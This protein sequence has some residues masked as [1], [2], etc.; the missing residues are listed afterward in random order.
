MRPG[1]FIDSRVAVDDVLHMTLRPSSSCCQQMQIQVQGR[2]RK[3]CKRS[4]MRRRR[5]MQ[6]NC[7]PIMQ[8]SA[9]ATRNVGD[10]IDE[11]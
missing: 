4:Q 8:E 3:V 9:I 2:V 1:L 5:P 11:P 10:A 7:A 6:Q